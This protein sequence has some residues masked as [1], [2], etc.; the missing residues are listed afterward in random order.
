ML[1]AEEKSHER[2]CELFLGLRDQVAAQTARLL[3]TADVLATLDVLAALAELAVLRNYTRPQLVAEPILEIHDGR[4][5]VLE[6]TLPPG[7]FVPNEV[8]LGR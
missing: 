1:G 6:Q 8:L 2:E 7:T 4:H 5:P 3:Q